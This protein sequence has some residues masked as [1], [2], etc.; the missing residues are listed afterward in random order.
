[1]DAVAVALCMRLPS[2]GTYAREC[3]CSCRPRPHRGKTRW[4]SAGVNQS[5][6]RTARRKFLHAWV[7][8]LSCCCR[9]PQLVAVRDRTQHADLLVLDIR[10]GGRRKDHRLIDITNTPPSCPGTR[11]PSLSGGFGEVLAEPCFDLSSARRASS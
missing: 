7:V 4:I 11:S 3:G 5:A 9:R 2:G 1:M 8:S 10:W 6:A